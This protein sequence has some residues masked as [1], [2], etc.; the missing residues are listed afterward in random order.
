MF[1]EEVREIARRLLAEK[2]VDM[3]IGYQWGSLPF[4]TSPLFAEELQDVEKMIFN[5]LCSVNLSRY[6]QRYKKSDKRLGIVAKGCDARSLIVLLQE[7][8]F[9]RERLK[10]IGVPCRGILDWRKMWDSLGNF[11]HDAVFWKEEGFVIEG[12]EYHYQDF[13]ENTCL[14]CRYP[15]PPLYDFLVGEPLDKSNWEKFGLDYVQ[16]MDSKSPEKRF[17]ELYREL[18]SCIRCYACREA[19]PLCYCN[20]CFVEST[21]PRW[22]TP[23]PTFSDN[24]VFHMGRAMHLAGRCVEC[25]ACERACPVGIPIAL[26]TIKVE[27]IVKEYF[28]FEAGL[29]LEEK[30]PLLTYK[31]NDPNEFIK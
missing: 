1:S 18:S 27:S 11:S 17:D 26:L 24:F 8:Q 14:R 21:H 29:S 2:E 15:N 7:E 5:P 25:G 9:E 16:E 3:I 19:C 10:I 22:T 23:C 4:R 20:E 31:E 30:A 28:G 12:K 6:L 13:M